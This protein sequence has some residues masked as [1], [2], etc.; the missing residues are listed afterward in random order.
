[1]PKVRRAKTS[2]S[3]MLTL[4]PK[5]IGFFVM[6]NARLSTCINGEEELYHIRE[7]ILEDQNE[8]MW[9]DETAELERDSETMTSMKELYMMMEDLLESNEKY[10]KN[11]DILKK[12]REW[13]KLLLERAKEAKQKETTETIPVEEKHTTIIPDGVR[14][15]ILGRAKLV[16][17]Q[18]KLLEMEKRKLSL[19][20][21]LL[22]RTKLDKFK[23]KEE[24]VVPTDLELSSDEINRILTDREKTK[25]EEEKEDTND[26]LIKKSDELKKLKTADLLRHLSALKRPRN[27]ALRTKR[28]L[29]NIEMKGIRV[30]KSAN[31]E[32]LENCPHLN[33]IENDK[34][35]DIIEP[36]NVCKCRKTGKCTC[37]LRLASNLINKIWGIPK[38]LLNGN[39]SDIE[40]LNGFNNP[41]NDQGHAENTLENTPTLNDE[42][43]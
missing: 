21:L 4:P 15:M 22:D 40:N 35:S 29:Q 31:D 3:V 28:E 12:T 32:Q 19:R 36:A 13:K 6:P 14:K 17:T 8:N 11:P 34:V 25:I 38:E 27:S 20:Q 30:R 43:K 24:V 10:Y 42:V 26:E 5:S 37:G 33:D 7:E 39:L 23:P 1:M 41:L 2:P 16:E 18:K 9:N